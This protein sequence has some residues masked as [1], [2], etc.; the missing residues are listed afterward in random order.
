MKIEYENKFSDILLFHAVHQFLSPVLQGFYILLFVVILMTGHNWSKDGFLPAFVGAFAWYVALWLIQFVF[1]AI[2]LFS[3][4][5]KSVLTKHTVEIQPES[6][7]EE[8][9]YN[10]SYFYWNG[11][12]KVVR[13]PGFVAV[14]VTPHMAHIIPKRA[15]S[16][17]TQMSSFINEC[18]NKLSAA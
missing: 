7:Y 17:K 11:I 5:N 18:K 16:S 6:F 1:N 8:T 12:Y 10:K 4:K 15:F 2:Y 13:R 9:K 14:Y 3:R